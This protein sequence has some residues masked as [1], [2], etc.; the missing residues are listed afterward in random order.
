[1][2]IFNRQYC[3]IFNLFNAMQCFRDPVYGHPDL[4]EGESKV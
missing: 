2:I 1:M 4:T 3:I